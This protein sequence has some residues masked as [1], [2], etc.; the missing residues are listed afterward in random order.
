MGGVWGDTVRLTAL[1]LGQWD[2]SEFL[3]TLWGKKGN[4]KD[5]LVSPLFFPSSLFFDTHFFLRGFS[6]AYEDLEIY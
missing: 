1:S 2:T 4:L 6:P 3:A 5:F